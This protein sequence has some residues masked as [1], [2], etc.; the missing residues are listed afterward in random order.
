MQHKKWMVLLLTGFIGAVAWGDPGMSKDSVKAKQPAHGQPDTADI[1]VTVNGMVCSFCA[2]GITKKFS[3]LPEV[4]KVDVRLSDS[5]VYI[6]TRKG[7]QL[8]DG[9]IDKILTDAGY[10]V[11][12]IDRVRPAVQP[13]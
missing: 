5:R 3:A 10:S 7:Q 12:K 1:A 6:T 4:E 13:L 2:Q 11:D 9:A 8:D